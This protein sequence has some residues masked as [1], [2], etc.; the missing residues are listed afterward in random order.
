MFT[1]RTLTSLGSLV[2]IASLAALA[3]CVDPPD[4]DT[5]DLEEPAAAAAEPAAVDAAVRVEQAERAMEV[6]RDLAAARAVLAG[7]VADGAAPP[8]VRSRASMALSRV[9]EQM[10][11]LEGAIGAVE[12]LL[13]AHATDR[14]W[15][16]H[17]AADARLRKLLTGKDDAPN[18]RRPDSGA[19]PFAKVLAR[20]FE[21]KKD[22]PTEVS[23]VLFGGDGPASERL[24]TFRIGDAL[25]EM[26]E[27]ACPL[28]DA[29]SRTMSRLSRSGSWTAIPME[30][31]QLPRAVA[32][33][34]THLADPIPARY[35]SL[36]PAP[37]AEVNAHLARGEAFVIAKA[38]PGAPP[39]IL[40]AAPREAQLA[41]VEEAL[42]RM[43][44]LPSSLTVVNVPAQLKPG[45]IQAV[46]R[47]SFSTFAKC[48]RDLL[49][50]NPKAAGRAVMAFAIEGDG[51]T[52]DVKVEG[53]ED[54][55]DAATLGCLSRAVGAI[56]FPATGQRTTV[57]YP[58][59]F[60]P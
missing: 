58:V 29:P 12:D 20:S 45:E 21:A 19:S 51:A 44:A 46:V 41:D 2:S 39:S 49:Q 24:G 7:V 55:T 43:S 17:H 13:A 34:Y 28:C 23:V 60:S 31:A 32:V 33:F 4:A 6:G 56:R 54:L 9:A 30:R 42:S 53:E 5:H 59:S 11:D 8:E 14:D 18:S 47:A 50:R 52:R 36:L 26:A 57:K 15:P 37:M 1:H 25:R 10:G 48:H 16:G 38:R 35:D 22:A 3:G 40:I 27:E